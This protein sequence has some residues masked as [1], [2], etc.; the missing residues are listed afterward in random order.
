MSFVQTAEDVR[1]DEGRF[2]RCRLQNMD[3]DFVDAELDLD[4]CI[5]NNFGMKYLPLLCESTNSSPRQL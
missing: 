1:V 3:G 4:S 2:L 5:G